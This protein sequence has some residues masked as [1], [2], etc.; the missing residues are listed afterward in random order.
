MDIYFRRD[1]LNLPGHHA[2]AHVVGIVSI[3][4]FFDQE[5]ELVAH[6]TIADCSRTVVLDFDA[7]DDAS[8]ANSLH[9]ARLLREVVDEFVVHLERAA[10]S[11]G[12]VA[13]DG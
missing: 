6:L 10:T 12:V 3:E 8:L 13:S 7:H 2:G 11:H 4:R 9:K 1:F 5:P